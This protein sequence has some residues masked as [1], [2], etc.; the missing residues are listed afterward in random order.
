MKIFSIKP[1]QKSA[2]ESSYTQ[3]NIFICFLMVSFFREALLNI[4]RVGQ[5]A[6]KYSASLRSRSRGT[7]RLWSGMMMVPA[8][9]P[10]QPLPHGCAAYSIKFCPA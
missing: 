2:L 10:V 3:Y 9:S 8:V 7:T 1:N 5:G 6:F 4:D